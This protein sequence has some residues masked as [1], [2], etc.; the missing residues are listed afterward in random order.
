[1]IFL[2]DVMIEFSQAEFVFPEYPTRF[3]IVL[4]ISFSNI[5]RNVAI[6]C[7]VTVIDET[8]TGKHRLYYYRTV[9]EISLHY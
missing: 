7:N 8:A 4:L 1:M 3:S 6:P 9:Y 5:P 2:S